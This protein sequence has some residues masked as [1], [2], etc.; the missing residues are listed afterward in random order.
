MYHYFKKKPTKVQFKRVWRIENKD[1]I[2]VSIWSNILAVLNSL[3][4]NF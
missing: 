3:K 2:L 1:V 4:D